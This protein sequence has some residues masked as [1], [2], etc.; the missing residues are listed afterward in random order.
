MFEFITGLA[1]TFSKSTMKTR[2]RLILL[3]DVL[4][5]KLRTFT[6]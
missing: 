6:A 2:G 1:F 4:D 5:A 3:P